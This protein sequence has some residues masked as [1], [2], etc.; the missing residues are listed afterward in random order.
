MLKK[1]TF[2][3]AVVKADAY[4][5]GSVAVASAVEDYVDGF[6]VAG[7]DEGV[8]LR[9]AGIK[10]P[11]LILGYTS[12]SQYEQLIDADIM[13]AI[14][15]LEDAVRLNDA[16]R[17]KHRRAAVHIAVDSGMN[18]IGFKCDEKSACDIQ[19]ISDLSNISIQGIFTH[20]S[21]A[22]MSS[23]E[24][25]E[26]T[27][28][29]IGRFRALIDHLDLRDVHI[30]FRHAYNSA[31]V[32]ERD[33][34]VFNCVRSGIIN[35]GLY[36]SDEVKRLCPDLEPVMQFKAR[37][38][39]VCDMPS[40]SKVG[41]GA[42]FVSDR[43]MKVATISAGYADGYPRL[44]S[45]KGR[46]IINGRYARIIGRVCMDQFMADVT[47]IPNVKLEDE[48]TLFGRDNGAFIPVEE[49]ASLAGTIN[50]ETVCGISKRVPRIVIS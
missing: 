10:K 4:G 3:F 1:D 15:R 23:D 47:D 11:V 49:V 35:Y 45:N 29:Q 22:D 5:H 37:V 12:P 30:P 39:N 31:A 46:V 32:I 28:E 42:T 43:N 16:A 27:D 18:R 7:A 40:G 41:Y 50:Y 19:K 34:D 14:W 21:C 8:T 6:A 25:V 44:L 20:L 24:A 26:Y 36:P 9:G 2:L 38:I 48:A 17:Q 33:N 13:P